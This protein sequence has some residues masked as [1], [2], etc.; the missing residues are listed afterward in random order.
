MINHTYLEGNYSKVTESIVNTFTRNHKQ[1]ASGPRGGSKRTTAVFMSTESSV[2]L[3]LRSG[4]LVCS[5][6]SPCI[7]RAERAQRHPALQTSVI[8]PSRAPSHLVGPRRAVWRLKRSSQ[9]SHRHNSQ[10]FRQLWLV[11]SFFF[12]VG[13]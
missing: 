5:R 2:S 7:Q 10:L 12:I 13:K 8:H 9:V 11:L 4:V 6:P 1:S 3:R